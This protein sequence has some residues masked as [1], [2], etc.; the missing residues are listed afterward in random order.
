[1]HVSSAP[2]QPSALDTWLHESEPQESAASIPVAR[3]TA[4]AAVGQGAG[5][6]ARDSAEGLLDLDV[7]GN[8]PTAAQRLLTAAPAPD[9]AA[10][11]ATQLW[12]THIFTP[13]E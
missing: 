4:P 10:P 8:N 7:W 3:G 1:M 11:G 9:A 5:G 12:A 2:L 13:L 6:P